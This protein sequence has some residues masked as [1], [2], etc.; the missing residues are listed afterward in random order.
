MNGGVASLMDRLL[1]AAVTG[2]L[3]D[4]GRLG[5]QRRQRAYLVGGVVRDLF[6][7][8]PNL[9]LDL[10]VEGSTAE[11]VQYLEET[12]RGRAVVHR[13]FGTARVSWEQTS[14]DLAT[15]RRETYARPG[16]LP[17]VTPGDIASDLARRDF[18]INAMAVDLSP[19]R[20]G[21]I[22]DLYGGQ[23]DLDDR[24]IRVLH[25]RS[26]V[27]DPTRMWR[28]VRYEQ[29]LDFRIE[30][31]TLGLLE[32][33]LPVLDAVTGDRIRHELERVLTEELP[34]KAL[35]RA[36][37]LGILARLQPGLTADRWLA[38][39]F[40]QARAGSQPGTPALQTYLALLAY[41]LSPP[42]MDRLASYLNVPSATR[43]VLRDTVALKTG[44][45]AL[46]RPGLK[47]SQVY[48]I[49]NG[50]SHTA[51]TA[52]MIATDIAPVRERIALYL[53]SLRYVKPLL[54]GNDFK[55]MGVPEGPRIGE[56]LGRLREARLD[57]QATSRQDEIDMVKRLLDG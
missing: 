42:E 54:T 49:L 1:P 50:Y 21:A 32:S 4:V 8:R 53:T 47:H 37:E 6:L 12:Y 20:Y 14:L 16:A 22:L 31:A 51:L 35:C 24:Y 38:Q 41:R 36:G 26:F 19:E 18:T 5:V 3:R 40:S 34:E 52:A 29:R 33:A 11:F 28:A 46:S 25:D 45:G 56:I 39:R 17:A 27:D 55:E 43:R 30:P 44:F 7:G 57:S 2:F 9:D 13:H 48:S 15:A 10:V 23:R